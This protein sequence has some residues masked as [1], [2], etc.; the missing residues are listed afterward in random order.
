MIAALLLITGCPN[1]TVSTET[2]FV[3]VTDITD[4]PTGGRAGSEV[5]LSGAKVVPDNADNK[6]IVWTVKDAGSTGVTDSGI[7]NGVF[8][9][10]TTGTLKLTATIA[11]GAAQGTPYTQ[12]FDIII[13]APGVFVPVTDITG[14]PTGGTAGT[15]VSLSG[16]TVVPS[17]ADNKAIVWTVKDAGGTGV[18]NSGIVNGSFTPATAGNL[19]L[20]A[21][22]ANGTAQ[23]TP[24]TQDFDIIISAPGAFV[25]VT[26]ITGVP[27]IGTAGTP[28]SLS[29][30]TVVPANATYKDISWVVK[31]PGAGVTS[32][33]G[34]TFTPT[35]AG[36][37]VL[38]ARI[39]SGAAEGTPYTDDFTIT[40]NP[41]F[42]AVTDING[43]PST[44]NAVT[45][46]ELNLNSGVTVVP[47]NATNQSIVWSVKS[48]GTTGLTNAT[49]ES[50]VFNPGNA[51]T[52]TLTA[53]IQNGAAQGQNVTK[54]T[55]ITIIKPVTGI[56]GVP[57]N[58]T[59]GYEVSLAGAT[60][61]PSDAT[62]KEIL[63][64][65]TTPGA[66]VTTISGNKFTPTGTGQVTLTA[67]ITNGRAVGTPF[68]QDFSITIN[69]PGTTTPGFGLG[70][71]TSI[72][73][74]GTLGSISATLSKDT[75]VA[76]EKNASYYVSVVTS[77]GSYT[78]VVWYLNGTKQTVT[79]NLIFLDTSV[80]GTIKLS[81][82]GKKGGQLES[83]G[84]Y[85][86]TIT[87]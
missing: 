78:D 20:T 3:P 72:T 69:E 35:E 16:A 57:S 76:I 84:T 44:R 80:S 13:S 51:G 36:S 14:V 54:E 9:P 24:Y 42:V 46:T 27:N 18:T 47:A 73:L 4:V 30:A 86:F 56:S 87:N 85:T 59:K 10:A 77:G 64:S 6:A 8:T 15:P 61:N 65:V 5:S 49:V 67:T 7:V 33:S 55:T 32:I 52:V 74:R 71:D 17:N 28:V 34:N 11:N 29:G 2:P 81:V 40:I 83:S 58:G 53:T 60:V 66:E 39:A 23:G 50:G 37:L 70:N 68:T 43:I 21:T 1:V 62:N 48:A 31:T 79:G 25:A 63:W 41:A 38:T 12:D 75:P 19:K 82:E 26:N 22:I 45:G